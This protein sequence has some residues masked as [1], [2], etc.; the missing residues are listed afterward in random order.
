M[1]FPLLA[2]L[3]LRAGPFVLPFARKAISFIARKP[4]KRFVIPSILGGALITSPTVRETALK[5]PT[6]PLT[7][8]KKIGA[9]IEERKE[10]K[11]R[12]IV[13]K[14]AEVA[15]PAGIIAGAVVLGARE[16]R[17][18]RRIEGETPRQRRARRRE[19]LAVLPVA[20]TPLLPSVAEPPKD[21]V[22]AQVQP[23]SPVTPTFESVAAPKEPKKVKR[24]RKEKVV[25]PL[26][27]NQIQIEN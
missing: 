15:L 24:I 14:A 9:V 2:G 19:E 23:I 12:G 10:R 21:T 20:A 4:I 13:A 17:K 16:L 26:V 11:P 6:A 22:T 7:L 3:A 8:G 5:A 18:R 25:T 27:I 1:V